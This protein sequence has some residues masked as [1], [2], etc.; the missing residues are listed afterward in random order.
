MSTPAD[1]SAA[2]LRIPRSV[3]AL[4]FV[5]MLMDISSEMI[6]ALLPVF[7][8]TTLSASAF[9]V[10]LIDGAAE[11][12]AEDA[13]LVLGALPEGAGKSVPE[14]GEHATAEAAAIATFR[15]TRTVR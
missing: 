11:A 13:S 6:H 14:T 9:T 7:L 3:W 5:S 1:S 8:V 10:G 12:T 2:R 4:G 15:G